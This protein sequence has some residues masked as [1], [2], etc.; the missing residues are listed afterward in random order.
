MIPA[1]LL[2]LL[3]CP[4]SG[5]P[6]ALADAG[7]LSMLNQKITQA[8]GTVCNQGGAAVEHPLTEGL[9]RVDLALLYPVRDHIPLLLIEEG[10]LL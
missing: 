5:Q 9:L 4:Q 8:P 7:T 1:D 2:V 10:I 3:R 6:L